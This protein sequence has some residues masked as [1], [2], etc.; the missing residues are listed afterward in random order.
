MHTDGMSSPLSDPVI[1]G[2][3]RFPVLAGLPL[4]Y[5]PSP[6]R[7]NT[8]TR[9]SLTSLC[10]GRSATTPPIEYVWTELAREKAKLGILRGS[11]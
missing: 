11:L 8:M 6:P 3:A 7:R 10:R 5:A 9:G 2:C 4:T 1:V